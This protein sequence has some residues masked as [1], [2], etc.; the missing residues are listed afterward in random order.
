MTVLMWNDELVGVYADV[1]D[2][3]TAMAED[4]EKRGSVSGYSIEKI[5]L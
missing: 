3:L 5:S 2:L 4:A 1:M